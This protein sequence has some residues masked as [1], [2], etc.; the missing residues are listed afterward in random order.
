M[1]RGA[2]VAIAR[3]SVPVGRTLHSGTVLRSSAL[4]LSAPHR[5]HIATTEENAGGR[6]ANVVWDSDHSWKKKDA[7]SLPSD[8]LVTRAQL[9]ALLANNSSGAL[10]LDLR[11]VGECKVEPGIPGATNIPSEDLVRSV[12]LDEGKWRA[13]YGF[14]KPRPDTHLI[15]YT[16]PEQKAK[17]IET[18]DTLLQHGYGRVSVYEGGAREWN[19]FENA[20]C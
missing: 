3:C 13:R 12:A 15:I 20:T 7:R 17:A 1:R 19:K 4:H 8:Q 11:S 16:T 10:L 9:K 18:V 6:P 14:A 5:R 2:S